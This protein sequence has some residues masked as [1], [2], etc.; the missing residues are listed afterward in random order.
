MSE[1]GLQ[2]TFKFG[3]HKGEQVEDVMQDDPGYIAWTA[4]N[5]VVDYDEEA[6]EMISKLRI[7]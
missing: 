5:D 6:M 4:E 2:D 1:I 7:V 3:K